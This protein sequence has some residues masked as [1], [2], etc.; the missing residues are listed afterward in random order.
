MAWRVCLEY[1]KDGHWTHKGMKE[2]VTLAIYT[3]EKRYP[4]HQ[5]VFIFD[6]ALTHVAYEENALV[7]KYLNVKDGGKQPKLRDT[8]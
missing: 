7:A 2:Q 4:D 8:V 3:F 1:N 5:A 6:N